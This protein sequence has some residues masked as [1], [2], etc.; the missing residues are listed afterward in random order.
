MFPAPG[1]AELETSAG[2]GRE[3]RR[4]LPGMPGPVWDAVWEG[5]DWCLLMEQLSTAG[6]SHIRHRGRYVEKPARGPPEAATR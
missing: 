6:R 4:E 2:A 3:D 5:M 1:P